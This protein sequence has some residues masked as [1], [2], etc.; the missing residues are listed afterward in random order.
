ML[1]NCFIVCYYK[2]NKRKGKVREMMNEFL[3]IFGITGFVAIPLIIMFLI[4]G[5][6]KA[7]KIGGAIAVVIFWILFTFM[8]FY[9]AE[10]NETAWNNGF[11][12]CGTHWELKGASDSRGHKI[13]YYT[14]SNCYAEIEI[15]C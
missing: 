10:T 3:V 6:D 13:K 9:E 15:N 14:C 1:D 4:G 8:M 7:H 11:C 5:V 2:Y 12:E